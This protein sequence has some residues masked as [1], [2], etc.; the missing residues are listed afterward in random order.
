[1]AW[2]SKIPGQQ[3][4]HKCKT[5]KDAGLCKQKGQDKQNSMESWFQTHSSQGRPKNSLSMA[6]YH[7]LTPKC[8]EAKLH[9]KY[10]N[11]LV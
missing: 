1:M 6:I 11:N 8:L 5:G 10:K 3:T 2:R 4:Q 7:Q 9:T